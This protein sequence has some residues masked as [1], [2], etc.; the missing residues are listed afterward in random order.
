MLQCLI[1]AHSLVRVEHQSLFDKIYPLWL[2]VAEQLRNILARLVRKRLYIR[3]CILILY[4][5]K[6]LFIGGSNYVE[7]F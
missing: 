4:L 5:V 2:R 3:S 6:I 1:Y 7:Y